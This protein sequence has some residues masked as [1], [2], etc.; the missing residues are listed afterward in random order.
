MN[1]YM[2]KIAYLRIIF[3]ILA[4]VWSKVGIVNFATNLRKKCFLF[5]KKKRNFI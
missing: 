2:S 3:E 4:L 5:K 1:I